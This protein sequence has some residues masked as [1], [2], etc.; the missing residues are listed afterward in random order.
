M[1]MYGLKMCMFNVY[2]LKDKG[3]VVK[4]GTQVKKK[5]EEKH[6]YFSG[7]G[8]GNESLSSSRNSDTGGM[9]QHFTLSRIFVGA[10]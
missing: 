10:W 6:L 3:P 1:Y 5:I 7:K 2:G 8:S 9:D 4:G